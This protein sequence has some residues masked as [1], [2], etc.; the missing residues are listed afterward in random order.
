MVLRSGPDLSA[1]FL[2][3][4]LYLDVQLFL[5]SLHG[6]LL[7]VLGLILMLCLGFSA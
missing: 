3:F 2:F 5:T 6:G 4:L 7:S 1:V